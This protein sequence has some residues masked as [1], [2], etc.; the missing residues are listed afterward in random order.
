MK[1]RFS[2]ILF[3]LLLSSCLSACL[4]STDIG[5]LYDEHYFPNFGPSD[6]TENPG[7]THPQA[8]STA[9]SI[10]FGLNINYTAKIKHVLCTIGTDAD[11]VRQRMCRTV[12]YQPDANAPI[13]H[14]HIFDIDSLMPTTKYYCNVYIQDYADQLHDGFMV[15]METKNLEMELR[16]I[17]Y[18][19]EVRLFYRN[20]GRKT[21]IGYRVGYEADLSDAVSHLQSAVNPYPDDPTEYSLEF[22]PKNMLPN[23]TLYIQPMVRQGGHT[24]YGNIVPWDKYQYKLEASAEAAINNA[25]I[26]L[27]GNF[28]YAD[29]EEKRFNIGFYFADHPI[30]EENL[31][32]CYD[33]FISFYETETQ[34]DNLKPSTTYYVRPFFA[35][36]ERLVLMSEYSF[37]T[38]HGFEGEV[39]DIDFYP[40]RRNPNKHFYVRF[41]RVE[42]GTFTMGA[43][44]AQEPYAEPD[45]YPAHEVTIDYPYYIC[46]TEFTRGMNS[47]VSWCTG[48]ELTEAERLKY[49]DAL[50][51]ID[52]I[53]TEFK[54]KGF[55]LPTEAEWEY[56]ARGGHKADGDWLYAG[57]DDYAEVGFYGREVL[58]GR[59]LW[60]EAVKTKA[61]NALGLYD[62]SGNAAEWC[63]DRYDADYYAE[64]PNL[65]PTG[66]RFGDDHV[67]RGGDLSPYRPDTDRRV[68]NRWHSNDYF[69][70][71]TGPASQLIGMRL[72]YDPRMDQE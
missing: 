35:K 62:M 9:T 70:I 11:S 66:S 18:S 19:R 13:I 64:S 36:D 50:G 28:S 54:L 65:N 53:N 69:E 24:F 15:E 57:S 44:P 34:I 48:E 22:D 32:T 37:D 14:T 39:C 20:V 56:A 5:Q 16:S 1:P 29:A 55:R 45:E 41:I 2:Y 46:E 30:T 27:K 21:S 3:V 61:P 52:R 31:G 8:S 63:S 59:I 58:E 12:S 17:E 10:C 42:P 23:T 51:L 43:T 6:G 68:S 72:V 26:M 33:S 7:L 67:V 4:E 47:V 25:K 71:Y 60:G 49:T 38:R 40:A